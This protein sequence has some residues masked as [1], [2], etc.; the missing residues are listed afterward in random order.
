MHPKMI[1]D[2]HADLRQYLEKKDLNNVFVSIIEAILTRKP[3]NPFE[4]IVYFLKDHYPNETKG[5]FSE[6]LEN[7]SVVIIKVECFIGFECSCKLKLRVL[8]LFNFHLVGNVSIQPLVTSYHKIA[9]ILVH[10]I[11]KNHKFMISRNWG[12]NLYLQGEEFP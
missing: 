12:R 1:N 11:Q 3:D 6:N 5:A 8:I 9:A 10:P 7:R 4:F 2:A